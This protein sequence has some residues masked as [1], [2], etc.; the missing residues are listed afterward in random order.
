MNKKINYKYLNILLLLG[1]IYLLF[2][3][4]DLWFGV[5]EKIFNILL[6]FI[7]AFLIA[8]VLYPFMNFLV[9]KKVP[10]SLSIFIVILTIV[11]IFGFTCY[12]ALPVFFNQLINLLANLGK[13]STDIANKYNID[14]GFINDT[15]GE[16]TSKIIDYI[17]III[18]DGTIFNI[19][20]KSIDF[21]TK[22][23]IITI[24]SIYF[25]ADM[26]NIYS[27][28]KDYLLRTNKKR[29]YLISNLNKEV[30]SYLKGLL[31]FMIIQFFEYTILFLIIGH[32]NFLLIG[33]LASITT[34]IPY[35]GGLITNILALLIAS[36]IS[37]KLFV[38]TLIITIVCPNIDGYIISPKIYGKTNQLPALLSIFAVF[39][40]GA[41]LGFSGIIIAVP[42]TIIILSVYKTYKKEIS[43]KIKNIK[44]RKKSKY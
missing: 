6:P 7:I 14:L 27:K 16:Y 37:P 43:N 15:I 29:Y 36:V 13:I 18:S 11:S 35:F 44:T 1:I 10:K 38:L 39:A 30:Y 31:I 9:K 42:L 23:I 22:F 17:G 41:L 24:A 25:L 19:V 33:V 32:P 5:V 21:I 34:I 4:K 3:M 28:V 8:Y 20:N 2:L 12:F 26:S 40:G